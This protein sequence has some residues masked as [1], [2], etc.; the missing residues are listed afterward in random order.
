V[1]NQFKREFG[2]I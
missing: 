1:A 2:N